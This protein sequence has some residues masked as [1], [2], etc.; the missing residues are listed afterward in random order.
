MLGHKKLGKNPNLPWQKGLGL[1]PGMLQRGMAPTGIG[2]SPKPGKKGNGK[3]VKEE[4]KAGTW[5]LALLRQDGVSFTPQQITP[6]PKIREKSQEHPGPTEPV[7][8]RSCCIPLPWDNW[9]G[10]NPNYS[11]IYSP[12]KE[13]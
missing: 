10:R 2:E 7:P 3:G 9:E 11:W 4:G 5:P 6:M 13:T 1:H 8:Q 12:G